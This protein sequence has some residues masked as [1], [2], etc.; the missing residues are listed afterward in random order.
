MYT[1][2]KINYVCMDLYLQKIMTVIHQILFPFLLHIFKCGTKYPNN[3]FDCYIKD[4]TVCYFIKI[5][6]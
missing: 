1:T 3:G 5:T 4:A 2:V 6:K